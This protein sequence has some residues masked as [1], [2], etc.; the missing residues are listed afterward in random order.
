[1]PALYC[2][3]ENQRFSPAFSLAE[4]PITTIKFNLAIFGVKKSDCI[5]PN[6]KPSVLPST[7][8]SGNLTQII[9]N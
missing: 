7:A 2:A 9:R 3:Y 8:V 1:M 6:S 4:K 5:W